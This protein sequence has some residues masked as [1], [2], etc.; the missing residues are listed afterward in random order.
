M[1]GGGEN[2]EVGVCSTAPLF[3]LSS[4]ATE[5]R[6][7]GEDGGREVGAYADVEDL[8]RGEDDDFSSQDGLAK[9]CRG[10]RGEEGASPESGRGGVGE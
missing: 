8:N 10:L 6:G 1:V 3:V 4:G 2:I 7:G 9:R 5:D